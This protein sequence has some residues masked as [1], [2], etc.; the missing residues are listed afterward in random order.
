MCDSGVKVASRGF[1]LMPL[2][3]TLKRQLLLYVWSKP[4][5]AAV[6]SGLMLQ[7]YNTVASYI[8]FHLL[9]FDV[10]GPH[11]MRA[12]SARRSWKVARHYAN[13]L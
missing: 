7:L 1:T 2:I 4:H 9:T 10:R 11:R 8:G 3:P 5:Q 12:E 6:E 13:R